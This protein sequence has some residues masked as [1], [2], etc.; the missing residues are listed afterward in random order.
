[1]NAK[2]LFNFNVQILHQFN[3]K[4]KVPSFAPILLFITH[5]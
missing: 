4:K 2:K 5:G 1:M 3:F